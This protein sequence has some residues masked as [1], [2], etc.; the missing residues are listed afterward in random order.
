MYPK[1]I[2]IPTSAPTDSACKK[3]DTTDV[4]QML[5]WVSLASFRFPSHQ[6]D[7]FL[8]KHCSFSFAFHPCP[9]CLFDP[10]LPLYVPFILSACVCMCGCMS[11]FPCWEI[12]W[13]DSTF[14]T[15]PPFLPSMSTAT[16]LSSL[17]CFHL[18]NVAH[19]SGPKNGERSPSLP[20]SPPL[21]TRKDT[22][23]I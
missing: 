11:P 1:Q 7:L 21:R 8:A 17:P 19:A 6:L 5:G 15:S 4:K 22:Q 18:L 23:R 13:K 9:L 14:H 3:K 16:I 10:L 2:C 12:Q 20:P